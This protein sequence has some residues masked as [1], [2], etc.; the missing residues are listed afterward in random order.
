MGYIYKITNTINGKMY[1]GQTRRTIEERWKQHIRSSFSDSSFDKGPFHLAI[2]KYG[3]DTFKVEQIEECNN[4]EL[5]DRETYWIEYFDARHKGY[6]ITT[7]GE[8]HWKWE[9]EEIME[10]WNEG[11]SIAEIT[12]KLGSC[13]RAVSDRLKSEGVTTEETISR[14]KKTSGKTHRLPVYMYDREG[15]YLKE[16]NSKHEAAEEIGYNGPL[17]GGQFTHSTICGYQFRRYK[18]DKLNSSIKPHHL[19]VHQYTL[20]GE[21]V[22]SYPSNTA[23][24]IAVTGNKNNNTSIG[25]VCNKSKG[26]TQAYG[27]R[28]SYEKVDKLPPIVTKKCRPVIRISLD[29]TERKLYPSAAQAS[30][31]NNVSDR[32]ILYA[33]NGIQHTSAGYRWEYADTKNQ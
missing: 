24:A 21:Y 16:F 9:T 12:K 15:N 14:G 28:W 4:E 27:Y 19:E 30:R 7:G 33:C 1:I 31:E 22:A 13:N 17:K 29:G 25:A 23:A 3:I 10:L 20:E 32:G 8:H 11:L 18:V 5:N 6:N 2:K 26:R